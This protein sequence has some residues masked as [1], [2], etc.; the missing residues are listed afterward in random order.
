[1]SASAD[2]SKLLKGLREAKARGVAAAVRGLDV[3]GEHVI[4]DSQQLCPVDTG[5][6]KASGT[7]LPAEA[8]GTKLSKTIGH[9]VNY[10]AAVHERLDQHHD[11]GQAKFLETA[12]RNNAPKMKDFIAAEV[13]KAL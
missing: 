12:I 5:A 13:K 2:I 9:N 3:F 7:T 6:L 8:N 11:Q 4:G 1:M 10:A